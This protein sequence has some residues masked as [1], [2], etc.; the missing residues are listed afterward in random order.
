[1]TEMVNLLADEK[2]KPEGII[3]TTFTKKAAVELEERVRVSLLEKGMTDIADRLSGALI[4]TV[5]S[6]G[7]K[8]L[9]RFAF[10]VGVS[11]DVDIIAEEDQS[12]FFNQS[13]A[14][15]L[16]AD[17]VERVETSVE[18]L[19]LKSDQN[20]DWRKD[21]KQI[22][23]IASA[24]GFDEVKMSFS[25]ESSYAS[26]AA[27]FP[28][29]STI[30]SDD[31]NNNFIQLVEDTLDN[32]KQNEADS[33][34]VTEKYK[35][36]LNDI[37]NKNNNK[38]SLS[39]RDWVK[40]YKDNVGAKSKDVVNELKE[41]AA[42]HEIHPQFLI[43]HKEYIDLI[44]DIAMKAMDEYSQFKTKR[45]LI[46]YLDMETLVKKLLKNDTV[47]NV[48]KDELNL[49]MVDEF[50]DTSPI[51][52]E[53]FWQLSQIA[54]YSIWVGDPKQSIYGFR[55][56]D[57][58][59]MKEI[60]IKNGG[61][62]PE[63]IQVFSWRSREDIVNTTNAIFT[64]SFE[65]IPKEQVAL[66]P[67]RISKDEPLAM[68]TAIHHWSFELEG[69][70]RTSQGWM[71]Q[72][73]AKNIQQFLDKN[74]YIFDKKAD[75]YRNVE[76]GDIAVLCHSNNL[77]LEMAE[78]LHHFGIQ[79]ATARNGL[80]N[81]PEI[82]LVLSCLKYILNTFDSLA[83]AEIKYLTGAH[84]L[85][86]V[87]ES[88]IEWQMAHDD[89][90]YDDKWEKD[91]DYIKI[92]NELRPQVQELSSVEILDLLLEELNIWDIIIKWGRSEQRKDNIDQLRQ[93][94]NQYEDACNRLHTGASLGGYL[95]WLSDLA[96]NTN[97]KMAFSQRSDA[98]NVITY[99]KSKGL[100]WPVV[101]LHSLEKGL[102]DRVWGAQIALTSNE[103][104][105]EN[106]SQNRYIRFW[107]HAY[108]KSTK[109][110]PLFD[111]L[112]QSPIKQQAIT[113]AKEEDS[114]VLYVG[115]TRARDY[116]VFTSRNG[117]AT[118]WLN[119]TYN[120]LEQENV[121]VLNEEYESSWMWE[122]KPIPMITDK[123][124]LPK[125][126]EK[127]NSKEET[128]TTFENRKGKNQEIK[129]FYLNLEDDWNLNNKVNINNKIQISTPF[130]VPDEIS[131]FVFSEMIKSYFL[132][133]L[134]H[135]NDI[136]RLQTIE[137]IINYYKLKDSVSY[138]E[139]FHHCKHFVELFHQ[140]Y[141]NAEWH[142]LFPIQF[143]NNEKKWKGEVEILLESKKEVIAIIQADI[144][145]NQRK[146]E[147][148]IFEN[149]IKNKLIAVNNSLNQTF[150]DK[151]IFLFVHFV[152]KGMLFEVEI[153]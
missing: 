116:L 53:I 39:W 84:S 55:G 144:F 40:V 2:V 31:F 149:P 151:K 103:F 100:E 142:K 17:L 45:G 49:L 98:V 32:L 138:N 119:R 111:R 77:C 73:I 63:D 27:L 9:K 87:V 13:L 19:S 29:P 113:D 85:K 101:I 28:E 26:L 57:P 152:L 52:L 48:L 42:Q 93:Y 72:C 129:P 92:L 46:D 50:Q 67:K 44:F 88:R 22:M 69:G 120:G 4:G 127:I 105:L 8:L 108:G 33:T 121:N 109:D 54:N 76:A 38:I 139:L 61:I 35:Y 114:R 133:D 95:L 10:E 117:T 140:K 131:N 18:K 90:D 47:K 5:H 150:K 141:P 51:Q 145:N 36:L 41:F 148:K 134:P 153:L 30:S 124:I 68:E 66:N 3:A 115:I 128:I 112:Q 60:I 43:D 64:Q 21:V 11:P 82:K 34:K 99:H 143:Q 78:A 130:V 132:Y 97:D 59:L 83:V 56:A 96:A 12:M 86:E 122:E 16:H 23:D 70:G 74:Y 25:K 81:M 91:N 110:I 136:S 107:R 71:N 137:N 24:N 106:L 15:I 94:A 58:T 147:P 126:F 14:S 89:E 135:Y 80:L 104:N 6:L 37:I 65:D 102:K 146:I 20:F 125:I 62:K 123:I 75:K 118:K 79:A 7:V 1:M